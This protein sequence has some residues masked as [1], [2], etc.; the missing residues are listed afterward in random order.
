MVGRRAGG[1]P[2]GAAPRDPGVGFQGRGGSLRRHVPA[3]G[4]CPGHRGKPKAGNSPLVMVISVSL[5]V[6]LATHVYHD[7][8]GSQFFGVPGPHNLCILQGTLEVR[9]GQGRAD[10]GCRVGFRG[11]GSGGVLGSGPPGRPAGVPGSVSA[12]RTV[13]GTRAGGAVMRTPGPHRSGKC[14]CASRFGVAP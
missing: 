3:G 9:G 13:P 14:R 1:E 10:G 2:A 4:G 12:E 8:T 11:S 7:V 6:V 5:R